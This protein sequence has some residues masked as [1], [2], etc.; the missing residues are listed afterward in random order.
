V[1]GISA[2]I[3]T[4]TGAVR[5]EAELTIFGEA[6]TVR[7]EVLDAPAGL[8]DVVPLARQ[9]ADEVS[10][11]AI[12]AALGEGHTVLCAKGCS[13]CCRYLVPLSAPELL[14]LERNLAMMPPETRSQAIRR[15]RRARQQIIDAGPPAPDDGG[16][17]GRSVSAW[18]ASLEM[19]CPFLTEQACGIYDRR[20]IAC[21]QHLSASSPELC[22]GHQP[23]VGQTVPVPLDVCHALAVLAAE[24]TETPLQAVMLP[25]ALNWLANESQHLRRRWP[26]PLL[27][28]R[29]LGILQRLAA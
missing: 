24:M 8:A 28:E 4:P 2:T 27:V 16:E 19:D 10:R 15:L 21:R 29:F 12:H 22:N 5:L 23:G 14:C 25:L 18:Y 13:A 6:T 9:I 3:S 20:P 17:P 11:R 7:A 26:G 1:T